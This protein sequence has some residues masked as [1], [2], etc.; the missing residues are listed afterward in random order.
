MFFAL[1]ILAMSVLSLPWDYYTDFVREHAYGLSNLTLAG[2]LGERAKGLLPGV[3][4]GSVVGSLLYMALW[5]FPRNWWAVAGVVTPFLMLILFVIAPVFISPL[6]NTYQPLADPKVRGPTL[7]LAR[8]NSVPVDNVYQFDASRQTKRISANVSGA[9]GTI[10]ISL[11]DN[12]LNRCPPAEVKA[13]M[14]HELGHY[15]LNHMY[16]LTVYFSLVIFA[17]LLFVRWFMA[18]A[19]RRWG[20]AWGVRDIADFAGYP[21]FGAAFSLFMFLATPVTNSIVRSTEAE[22]DIFGVNA[23]REPDAFASV[24]LKLAEYRKLAPGKWE[25]IIFYDHPSGR[26]R[27]LM[28][29]RWK[30][31]NLPPAP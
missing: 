17:G 5:R 16:Q 23:A 15:V 8:A 24:A 19:L 7:S 22:A 31:E 3:I 11:N 25:E 6:F 20:A 10:R 18:W 9:G 2:W 4:I 13:V 29:M 26:S 30:A 14:A 1:L 28:A 27:I 21:L 12:L